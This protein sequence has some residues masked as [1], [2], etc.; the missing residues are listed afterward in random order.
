MAVRKARTD[1]YATRFADL[2]FER[3][4]L[5][6]CI[7]D[8]FH[9]REVLYPGCSVYITP[10]FYFPSVVFVDNDPAVQAFFADPRPLLDLIKRNRR[11]RPT[12]RIQF[13]GRDF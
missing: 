5:F 1:A 6:E 9:P 13:L 12:P 10:A 4:G 8:N 3:G 7:R 2:D 11:Y